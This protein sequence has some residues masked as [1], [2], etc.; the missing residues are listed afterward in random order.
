MGDMYEPPSLPPGPRRLP[1]LAG[2]AGASRGALRLS[3][4]AGVLST[5][6]TG[7]SGSLSESSSW[8]LPI[9]HVVS[10]RVRV[11]V[12]IAIASS[13]AGLSFVRHTEKLVQVLE[14]KF[15]SAINSSHVL[16]LAL[17]VDKRIVAAHSCHEC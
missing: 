14:T 7:G 3:V 2:A 13:R 16:V 17:A 8:L 10:C 15:E 11:I 12:P 1:A 4:R 5:T 6:F 9:R